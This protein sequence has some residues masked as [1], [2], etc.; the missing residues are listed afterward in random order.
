MY[1]RSFHVDFFLVCVVFQSI[2]FSFLKLKTIHVISTI[3]SVGKCLSIYP[4]FYQI[5]LHIR[6]LILT[7]L[8]YFLENLTL[9]F[10]DLQSQQAKTQAYTPTCDP[11]ETEHMKRRHST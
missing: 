6:R 4:L 11:A 7:I 10:I 2:D 9:I 8:S 5:F 3:F 1:K